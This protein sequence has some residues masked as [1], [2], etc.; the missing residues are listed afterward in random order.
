METVIQVFLS[1][2]GIYCA[3]GLLFGIYFFAKGAAK[4][5]ELIPESKWTVKLLLTS[6]AIA[7]WP[8]LLVKIIAKPKIR[9]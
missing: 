2:F 8:L 9:S 4:L 1:L 6:G 5:D 3:I 7:L